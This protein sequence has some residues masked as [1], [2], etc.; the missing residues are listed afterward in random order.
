MGAT[1][2]NAMAESFFVSLKGELIERSAIESEAQA[3]IAV[4]TSTNSRSSHGSVSLQIGAVKDMWSNAS[5]L[6]GAA[7]LGAQEGARCVA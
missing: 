3:R 5:L 4:F 2:A 6:Q 7:E 1:F